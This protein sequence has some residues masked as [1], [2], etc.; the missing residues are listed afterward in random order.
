MSKVKK[1]VSTVT[2]TRQKA[3][4]RKQGVEDA[5]K[6]ILELSG[7]R[8][9]LT[10]QELAQRLRLPIQTIGRM[11]RMLRMAEFDIHDSGGVGV[12]KRYWIENGSAVRRLLRLPASGLT[13]IEFAA[14]VL[15][16]QGFRLHAEALWSVLLNAGAA[17]RSAEPD[18]AASAW[19]EIEGV[20]ARPHP[21]VMLEPKVLDQLRDAVRSRKLIDLNYRRPRA[22][23]RIYRM[24]PYGFLYGT[25]SSYL[26]GQRQEVNK[27]DVGL[28]RLDRVLGVT[29][30]DLSF[31]PRTANNLATLTA[32]SFGVFR[33]PPFD[34]EVIFSADVAADAQAWRFHQSQQSTLLP[35]GR[36]RVA[37]RAGGL[38]EMAF[39]FIQWGADVEVIAP[40][41]LRQELYG[42]G[43]LLA[44]KYAPDEGGPG[45]PDA[46]SSP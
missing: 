40:E 37:F 25:S 18:R 32:D 23:P 8:V 36:L 22:T 34:V 16:K 26:I 19:Q 15:E 43:A 27:P 12:A 38:K 6:L 11:M 21:Q 9:G 28:W 2:R 3:G 46:Q 4:Y 42:I 44:A 24:E 17:T 20:A 5:I 1:P 33:E 39:H 41:T 45:S 30:T 7:L 14:Q 29:V 35:D 31:R 10:N 13:S